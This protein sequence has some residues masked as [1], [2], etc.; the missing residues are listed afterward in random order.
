MRERKASWRGEGELEGPSILQL[1]RTVLARRVF[2]VGCSSVTDSV[3][4]L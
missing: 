4:N 1:R 3:V 2:A